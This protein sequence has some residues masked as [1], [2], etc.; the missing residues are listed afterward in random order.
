MVYCNIKQERS[1][2]YYKALLEYIFWKTELQEN[3]H[4]HWACYKSLT[5]LFALELSAV[6]VCLSKAWLL[7]YL[8]HSPFCQFST[9]TGQTVISSRTTKCYFGDYQSSLF[10]AIMVTDTYT[11]KCTWICTWTDR[12]WLYNRYSVLQLCDVSSWINCERTQLSE[13]QTHNGPIIITICEA[14]HQANILFKG[15][16]I[17]PR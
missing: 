11:H 10:W 8:F 2:H 6:C 17:W 13:L 3:R 14:T 1:K 5:H 15:T 7:S 9:Q 16:I 4:S 12:D